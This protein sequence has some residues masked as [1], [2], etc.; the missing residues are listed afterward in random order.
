ML[1][2]STE[3][4]DADLIHEIA[5]RANRVADEVGITYAVQDAA[6]DLTATHLNGCPLR[7]QALATAP[8]GEFGHDV[9]GIR[10][11]LN[12]ETGK[13]EGF[14]HPRYARQ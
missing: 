9:F 5:V 13:L 7:L 6:M 3:P 4:E 1:N 2:W 10:K 11:N 14:F 8:A 12:R